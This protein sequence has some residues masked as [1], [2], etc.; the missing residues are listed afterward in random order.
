MH[1]TFGLT[2]LAYIH[3]DVRGASSCGLPQARQPL[4]NLL[5]ALAGV[6]AIAILVLEL[7]ASFRS[8]TGDKLK[9]MQLPVRHKANPCHSF[10]Q[11]M[12]VIGQPK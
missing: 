3:Y 10:E 5:E 1:W 4:S 9:T 2:Q 8:S 11:V 6:R 12:R 7:S